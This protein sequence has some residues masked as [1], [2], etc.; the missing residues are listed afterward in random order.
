MVTIPLCIPTS[1]EWKS[2]LLHSLPSAYCLS[3]LDFGHS[4][5]CVVVSHFC[6]NLQF[7]NDIWWHLFLCLLVISCLVSCLSR[8]CPFCN[9]AVCFLIVESLSSLYMLDNSP[10]LLDMLFRQYFSQAVACFLIL[11]TLSFTEQKSFYSKEVQLINDF[12]Q[13]LCLWY[14]CPKSHHSTPGKLGFLLYYLL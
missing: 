12:F 3:V 10:F 14:L 6:F 9:Q 4:N 1:H 11:F 8:L 7:P 5:R 13:R 2:L